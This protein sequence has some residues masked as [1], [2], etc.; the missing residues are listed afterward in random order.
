MIKANPSLAEFNAPSIGETLFHEPPSILHSILA[1]LLS[2]SVT[3]PVITGVTFV[4]ISFC[5]AVKDM[6]GAE[7]SDVVPVV[8]E[9]LLA[10]ERLVPDM[11]FAAVEMPKEYTVEDER[12]EDGVNVNS[13]LSE[14]HE[15]AP[16]TNGDI[17]RA[18]S[19]RDVFIA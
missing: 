1:M 16:A 9:I 15:K 10:T 8:K 17:E 7:A 4:V 12:F 11:S 14:F 5:N 6:A 3:S 13:V 18:P 2:E 19:T